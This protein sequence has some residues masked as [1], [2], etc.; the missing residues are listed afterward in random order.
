L[1]KKFGVKSTYEERLYTTEINRRDPKFAE[2]EKIAAKIA[3]EIANQ[4]S[5]NNIHLSEERG[6]VVQKDFDEEARFSQVMD[7]SILKPT[8]EPTQTESKPKPSPI[9]EEKEKK[10]EE[11]APKPENVPDSK[12]PA[13][14]KTSEESTSASR[15][16]SSSKF[17]LNPNAREFVFNPNATEFVFDEN[18]AASAAPME[19]PDYSGGAYV[20]YNYGPPMYPPY[21]VP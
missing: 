19:E 18:S 5:S 14:R 17:A 4:S 7:A 16:S 20:D 10:A 12:S 11:T 9:P 3:D 6:K 15:K 1:N 21:A 2:K 13:S 8:A